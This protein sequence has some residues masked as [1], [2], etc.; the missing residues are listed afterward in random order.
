[1]AF[2]PKDIAVSNT[3]GQYPSTTNISLN[4]SVITVTSNGD[5]YPGKAGNPMVND[6]ETPRTGFGEGYTIRPQAIDISFTNRGGSNSV[7]PQEVQTGAIGITCTGVYIYSTKYFFESLPR[8]ITKKP[9]G[10]D[11]NINGIQD[12]LGF[13]IAG[14]RP[15]ENGQYYYIN[16]KLIEYALRGEYK[17][18]NSNDYYSSSSYG[19]DRFR[20]PSGH[21]KIIGWSFDG[22][23]IY[24]PYGF[25]TARDSNSPIVRMT[26]SYKF[27]DSDDH[28]PDGYKY[29]DTV[30]VGTQPYTLSAGVFMQD[31]QYVEDLGNLDQYNGR[32]CFTPE[33]PN[34]TYA[35]FMTF[36]DDR[37]QTP[38]Y[39][40]IVG[41]QTRQQR[42]AGVGAPISNLDSLWQQGSGTELTVLFERS[43]TDIALPV[44]NGI[45]PRIEVISGK[46]PDGLRIDGSK[47]VGTA[48]EV[49]TDTVFKFVLRAYFNG[50]FEDRTFSIV[51]T[52]P[53]APV[54]TTA[55]GLLPIGPNRSYFILD[56][57]L[58][59]F[60]INAI[61]PDILAGDELTFF[62]ADG[63][64]ELPPGITLSEDGRLYGIVEPLLALDK[65]AGAGGYD[66]HQYGNWL[67]DFG[68]KP[69]NGYGSFYYDVDGYDYSVPSTTPKK[70]NRYYE[71]AVTV[72]DGDSF[73]RKVFKIF[74]VGDDFL[75]ADN[76]IMQIANGLFT[77]DNTYL[78][79]PVWLTPEDLG[80]RRA[81]NYTTI[82]LDTIQ[83]DTL[84]GAVFYTL[85]PFNQDGSPSELPPGLS[86]DS[87]NGE[88]TGTIPYQ[89][90]VTIKYNFTVK[91]TRF[92]GDLD[93]ATIYA[94][95]YEDTL[96]GATSFKIIKLSRSLEDGID[97]LN[98]LRFRTINLNGREYA[99]TNVDG[100]PDDYDIIYIN[101]SVG[102]NISIN[103]FENAVSGS[104]SI[105]VNKLR[106]QA[107]NKLQY[108][109][110]RFS[111][112]EAYQIRE[113]TPYL[114]YK[115]SHRGEK[116]LRIESSSLQIQP[117]DLYNLGDYASNNGSIYQLALGDGA[118]NPIII[119]D[120]DS[121]NLKIENHGIPPSANGDAYIWDTLGT[122]PTNT[123]NGTYYYVRY[124]D[125]DTISLHT[126]RDGAIFN[127]NKIN[128]GGGTGI[129]TI[130]RATTSTIVTATGGVVDF[131]T[132]QWSLIATGNDTLTTGGALA[133][134]QSYFDR[135]YT[136]GTSIVKT[137]AGLDF[138]WLV[139]IPSTSYTRT[140]T[141]FVE[142]FDQSELIKA[143]IISDAQDKI[144][145][146]TPLLR[147]LDKGRNIGIAL[148][149]GD[150]FSRDIT[151]PPDEE[152]DIVE[153][154]KTFT[155]NIIGEVESEIN[156]IT[157][158]DLGTINANFISTLY[159]EA[160]TTVPNSSVLYSITE[161]RLPFGMFLNYDGQI[162]GKAR[163]YPSDGE[164]GLTTFDNKNTSFDGVR[165][166]N[167]STSFDREYKFTV[168][169]QD[170]FRISATEKEFIL[171]VLDEDVN[172]YSNIY[173]K[174]LLKENQRIFY[175]NFVS[176]PDVFTPSSVY[177][178]N[179]PEFGIQKELKMLVY[180]GIQTK[181]IG[182]FVAASAKNH[183][184][185]KYRLGEIKTAVAKEPGTEEILYEVIY[186]EVIDPAESKNGKVRKTFNIK[187]G[188]KITADSLQY[189]AKDDI[190]NTGTGI[191][192]L[193]VFGRESVKFIVPDG[194]NLIIQSRENVPYD[195]DADNLD[196]EVTVR[197]GGQVVVTLAVTD[198]E[199]YR[200]RPNTN[201][202]KADSNAVKVSQSKDVLKYISNIT[203]MRDEIEAI[204]FKERLY[205]PLWMRTAQGSSYPQELDF[206]PAIPICYCKP[207]TSYDIL[208]NIKN[209]G[210]DVST[211]NFDIDRYIVNQ[212][213][214]NNDEQYI[215]F[216]NYQFNV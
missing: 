66:T 196:F 80:F 112:N 194:N 37:L 19:N 165:E 203:N 176:N 67:Y 154:Q 161:G 84:A 104:S 201:T 34:G 195:V 3:T 103:L 89:P 77:A 188:N 74:L 23:P 144:T 205:L 51:V 73:D 152:V 42:T 58:V 32:Y 111:G 102:P 125:P 204:G 50:Q 82:Y 157:D 149:R 96:L 59:N 142:N 159:V 16:G 189:D 199:P 62:I 48:F 68:T 174:P 100:S 128:I 137:Y 24:G 166:E 126:T 211:I 94:Q 138:E 134:A 78:R 54:I 158:T 38:A 170:R 113:I 143:E 164:L 171:K 133:V 141:K 53:D 55:E 120:F 72:T 9:V 61:D 190:T 131:N 117:G 191:Q 119:D 1:M 64:G 20:H 22:F 29:T 115:V 146:D 27:K 197:D 200:L 110:L 26:S 129:H 148:F 151:A 95:F 99:V 14:G 202:I 76:T 98:E 93:T 86:L 139:T 13:D 153:S 150:A 216:P 40:Y 46:L 121:G 28:R 49:Q 6:G 69:D 130:D 81:N 12:L 31:F 136:Q 21:S 168:L 71:F 147:P 116:G 135:T 63:D 160:R 33:Y 214:G 155:I 90:A 91:A 186:I 183:K 175:N 198:S 57:S 179:D 187:N 75:R 118:E 173:M 156:W 105:F 52:G 169:A 140:I 11:W 83:T 15:L 25:R 7:N 36:T 41:P 70:L 17:V 107:K 177:R 87:R 5:P 108:R 65:T 172:T 45:N 92:S 43:T 109:Y 184:R 79:T 213:E 8:S 30:I 88:I 167:S 127:N 215:I 132:Q 185:K 97:D 2:D 180:A 181:S 206:V 207:G 35:Y 4:G 209:Q 182:E 212:T 122:N 56:N 47:I 208:L 123:V 101:D 85:E 192:E 210:F 124:I 44:A 18:Y 145:F 106:E 193:S 162:I 114:Q 10:F 178:P 60:H 163:Q 39:P